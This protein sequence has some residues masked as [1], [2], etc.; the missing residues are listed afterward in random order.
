MRVTSAFFTSAVNSRE[1]GEVFVILLTI[2]EDSLDAPIR[3]STDNG[4][5]FTVDSETVRGTISR[6]E[7]FIFFPMKI[8][9]ATDKDGV[10]P[11]MQI[12][13]ENVS[14][15]LIVA[16]RSMS[17]PPTVLVEVVL[18]SQHDTVEASFANFKLSSADYD[19]W[20]TGTL[21]R[22]HF[23]TEPY[24]GIQILPSNFPG[25]F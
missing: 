4:D 18:A 3:V 15:D 24:P 8:S 19:M 2:D 21:S 10:P 9:L 23:Y 1:T 20:I 5:T 6:G 14:R 16:I 12:S 25:C 7:N 13:I 17:A 22:E 11:T